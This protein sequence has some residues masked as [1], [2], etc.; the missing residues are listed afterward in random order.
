MRILLLST[1][2]P[3]PPSNGSKLRVF[4][5]LRNLAQHHEVTLLSFIDQPQVAVNA[6]VLQSLCKELHVVIRKPYNKHSLRARFGFLNMTPRSLVDTFSIEMRQSIDQ[7]L[8]VEKYDLVIASQIGTAVY[9]QY[10][11]RLPALLEEVEVGVL[12]EQFI[13][14]TSPWQRLRYGLTWIKHQYYLVRL[15]RHYR[16]CTVVSE[17]EQQLLA[18]A[19][20]NYRAVEVI[21]NGVDLASYANVEG[22]PLPNSMIFAG[23]F[24]YVANYDAMCW[25]LSKVYPQIQ[26]QVPG[27]SLTITGDH[28][29]RVLPTMQNIKLTGFVDDVRPLIASSWI[30]L[31]PIRIGAG[32]RLKILEAMALRSPVVSTTKGAEGLDV[33]DD[34]HLLIA[35]TPDAFATAVVR[36]LREPGLRQRLVENAYQVIRQKYDWTVIAPRFLKLVERVTQNRSIAAKPRMDEI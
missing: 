34:E 8:S 1:W 36:L 11:R 4:N 13:K 33:K 9:G 2:F 27:A 16:G 17:R 35:D 6:Q 23:A 3:Y 32:T 21:P 19:A 24:T 18:R 5:L 29:N 15:L 10:F 26:A 22:T 20:P 31:A 25:F 12:Y 30:S 7:V 14:A 28:A